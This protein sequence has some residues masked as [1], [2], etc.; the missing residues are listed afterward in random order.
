[1][2]RSPY[3]KTKL[4]RVY[5]ANRE[6]CRADYWDR[7]GN[8]LVSKQCSMGTAFVRESEVTNRDDVIKELFLMD[9]QQI[10]HKAIVAL[11][12]KHGVEVQ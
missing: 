2:S 1:M 4:Q 3:K 7:G 12:R 5:V 11:L 6:H 10:D 8:Q 9:E